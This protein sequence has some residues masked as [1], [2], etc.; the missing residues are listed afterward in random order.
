MAGEFTFE[1]FG[2]PPLTSDGAKISGV[3]GRIRDLRIRSRHPSFRGEL[4]QIKV[5]FYAP[6]ASGLS[7]P[8]SILNGLSQALVQ[9]RIFGSLADVR[10]IRYR[11]RSGAQ[12][13][14]VVTV[15]RFEDAPP[16]TAR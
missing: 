11:R 4:V 12:A 10:D 2:L 1:L 15:S 6:P 5:R 3:A 16:A 13:R 9:A 8:L 7:S 14:Y